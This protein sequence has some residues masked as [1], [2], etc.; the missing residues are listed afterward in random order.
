MLY[1][2]EMWVPEIAP[3]TRLIRTG[4]PFFLRE[5]ACNDMIKPINRSLKASMR[6]RRQPVIF[7]SSTFIDLA[8]T[9]REIATWL[10]G[11][12]G[13][14]LIV[15]ETFGS[16][17][18]PPEVNSVRRVRQCDLFVGVYAHRYGTIDK[19]TAKSITEL[20]LD[21]A[22]RAHSAGAVQDIL[23]YLIDQGSPWL[24]KYKENNSTARAGLARLR[25]KAQ[26]HTC[27]S[28]R[29]GSDLLFAVV[30]DVH[31]R[32][33]A[34]TR[35]HQPKL[36]PILVPSRRTIKQP[37]G[38][39]F[40]T[41]RERDYLV[42]RGRE[43]GELLARCDR[44]PVVLLLGDSGVGK[45]SL[46]HAGLILRAV[47]EGWRPIYARPFGLPCAD[48]VQQVQATLYEKPLGYRGP[49]FPVLA[50]AAATV[51]GK[52]ILLIIDQ[53]EDVLATQETREIDDLLS[54][55]TAVRELAD[56]TVRV[57]ISYRADLEGR[58]GEFWQRISGSPRGLPRFY[59]G[60]ISVAEAWVGVR[61]AARDFS[62]RIELNPT[63][64]TRI[65]NDLVVASRAAGFGEVYPPYLQMLI[66]HI[67]S[68]ARLQPRRAYKFK[69]YRDTGGMEGVIGGYLS[70][71]L[72][73]ARDS[74]GHIRSVLVSLVRSYGVRAQRSLGEIVADTGLRT[75]DCDVAL[76]RL[77]DLRLVRHVE[78]Y[79][80]VTHDFIAKRIISELADSEE[81]EVKRS[82]ELLA[83][84]AATYSTTGSLLAAEELLML[85]KH[86]ERVVP[87]EIE[88]RLLLS[89]WIKGNGPALYWLLKSGER[90]KFLHWL[91]SE[92][93]REDLGRDEKVAIVLLRRKLGESPLVEKDYLAFRDYQL[94]AELAFL[95]LK[96]PLLMPK[97]LLLYGLRHRRDEVRNACRDV[98]ALRV[99]Q[100][101]WGW[102]DALRKSSS[103]DFRRAYE[104]LI[105]RGDVPLPPPAVV[106][107]SRSTREFAL[108]KQ[109]NL[110]RSPAEARL[111][112]KQL[113]EIHPAVRYGLLG[114]ALAYLRGGQI[115]RLLAEASKVPAERAEVL[116]AALGETVN[117]VG[118]ATL[119][120]T[121]EKCC[122]EESGRYERPAAYSR[123]TALADAIARSMCTGH[124]PLLRRT[125]RRIPL[126]PSA[127]GLAFGL[128]QYGNLDDYRLLLTRIARSREPID[129]SNHTEL[130]H[131]IAKRLADIA[132]RVPGFLREIARTEEFWGEY[133]HPSDRPSWPKRKLLPITNVGNRQLYIRLAG[134]GMI[135]SAKQ[136]DRGLLTRLASHSY[137]LI[138][139]AAAISLVRL[140]GRSAL[141]QLAEQID[142]SLQDRKA[143]DL[144]DAIRFAEIEY[145]GLASLW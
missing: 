93:G 21:E 50:E 14:E 13:A 130:G 89:S 86:K 53:F 33:S 101:E 39:E 7:L 132:R 143:K 103:P 128:L 63:E 142:R 108:L 57:L 113:R 6:D 5:N 137:G 44:D 62:L 99:K 47:R 100:G 77:I 114:K 96:E 25:E 49:L 102:I 91:R 52:R 129:F 69:R 120:R 59:L 11:I 135:G 1:E 29:K 4:N 15:M 37:P 40:L 41:T 68:S 45:T 90:E 139:R 73:Y 16:D 46:I 118:F 133:I 34:G 134:Y 22:K 18:A 83:T 19:R 2:F 80:E 106:G 66:D 87:G 127:R 123:N 78:P 8:D 107:S 84:N 109:I 48:L 55:V 12:F 98:I 23:L 43:V 110:A 105:R 121:Y 116:L 92:E 35:V 51:R 144:A 3:P 28:F 26:Q 54:G 31:R 136:A 95:I 141:E 112:W 61:K 56:P 82:R 125:I 88:L 30:R 70:R 97:Q 111:R 20:E 140:M 76:E 122:R 27:T 36:R 32:L 94:S 124:L 79:Y 60:G 75:K 65:Q 74:Q 17:A 104:S 58:L 115:R 117:A 119:V 126:K 131:T 138:A 9:R 42:G 85:Y 38:M 81:R 71:Q 72:A 67:W 64:E 24:A 10:S 145:F